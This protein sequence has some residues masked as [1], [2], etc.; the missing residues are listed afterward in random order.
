M[1]DFD[2]YIFLKVDTQTILGGEWG[3][4]PLKTKSLPTNTFRLSH[5]LVSMIL[6]AVLVPR[7][8]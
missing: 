2:R 7:D 3:Y 1:L 6:V 8:G 4:T 5:I